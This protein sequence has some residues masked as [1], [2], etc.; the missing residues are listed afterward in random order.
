MQFSVK[1]KMNSHSVSLICRPSTRVFNARFFCLSICLSI[2]FQYGCSEENGSHEGQSTIVAGYF[3]DI[4]DQVGLDFHPNPGREGSYF[5]PESIGSGAAFLDYDNDGDLDIYLLNGAWHSQQRAA[6]PPLRNQLFQQQPDGTFVN[7]T[8]ESGL[9]DGGYGMGVAAGDIDN[10]GDVDVYISN[11]GADALYRNNGDGTFSNITQSAGIDNPAW[12]CS[13]I[14][15][16]VDR[17]SFLDI[18]V[19]N[20][21][22]YDPQAECTDRAGR[23]DYCGPTNFAGVPDILYRNN[24]DGT[25]ADISIASGVGTVASVSLGVAS[26]DFNDDVFPDIYVAND[27][28]ENQLWINQQDG[29]FA[30][31]ATGLGVAVNDVGRREAG[32]GIAIGDVDG[33][34]D[35][36]VF[37]THLR[38][39]SNT[40]YR[41]ENNGFFI[42]ASTSSRLAAPSVPF[43]G[44]G[45]GFF[46]FDND[47]DLDIAIANGR[48]TRGMRLIER[49]PPQFW[50]DYAEPNQLFENDGTG[51]FRDI[52]SN[53][54]AF[55]QAVIENSRGLA[56][57]DVDNDGDLDMLVSN[58][59]GPARLF[60]NDTPAQ[61]NWLSIRAVLPEVQRDAIGTEITLHVSG[62][63]LKRTL[64]PGYSFLSSNDHRV[65]FGLG[66]ATT[67]DAISV[68]WPDG[69]TENFGSVQANRFILLE[70]GKQLQQ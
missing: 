30:D 12:G 50:D 18:F 69:E 53:A 56:F 52:S 1:Q 59:G 2:F 10:D 55:S 15:V 65:H 37:L 45:T 26:A 13:V 51:H 40:L 62:K 3:T 44:F 20:Y 58:E 63:R 34:L 38:T 5:M 17:D 60:R 41:N 42:D 61:G 14:F 16:D 31:Q 11:Y 32:M 25:F 70:K 49:Q 47:S 67:V 68:R 66:P 24:G 46:D 28:R 19:T 6:S 27:G 9:G 23:I 8:A 36:D 48:V 21:I 39:E 43:T 64:S 4:S 33:D 22:E 57:G 35:F 7:V 54:P 29:T